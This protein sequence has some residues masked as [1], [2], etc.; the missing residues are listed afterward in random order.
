MLLAL[1]IA[2]IK[3]AAQ[4]SKAAIKRIE[5]KVMVFVSLIEYHKAKSS[6][7][8]DLTVAMEKAADEIET[9]RKAHAEVVS[10]VQGK[11]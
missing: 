1:R 11:E 7:L 8:A 2:S 3:M 4:A 10:S 5:S 6:A 9:A